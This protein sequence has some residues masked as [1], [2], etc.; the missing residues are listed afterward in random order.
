MDEQLSEVVEDG[1]PEGLCKDVRN[2]SFSFNMI[3]KDRFVLHL[4]A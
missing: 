4:F 3:E 2:L 1:G